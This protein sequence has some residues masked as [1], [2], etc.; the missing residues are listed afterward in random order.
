MLL[1]LLVLYSLLLD[2]KLQRL[3]WV[4]FLLELMSELE[5]TLSRQ[6]NIILQEKL[7]YKT[8]EKKEVIDIAFCSYFFYCSHIVDISELNLQKTCTISF[9]NGKDDLMNFEVTV[10]PDEGY[11]L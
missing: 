5:S 1:Q 9:P 6:M 10:C 2:A 7:K 8:S 4:T 3:G 11:Y